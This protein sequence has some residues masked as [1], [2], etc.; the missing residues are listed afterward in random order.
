MG[1]GWRCIAAARCAIR[2]QVVRRRT[3]TGTHLP[4]RFSM[5]FSRANCCFRSDANDMRV[6]VDGYILCTGLADA[7]IRRLD[8]CPIDDIKDMIGEL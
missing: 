8:D 5:L 2:V 6:G 4:A 1:W 3:W 7:I